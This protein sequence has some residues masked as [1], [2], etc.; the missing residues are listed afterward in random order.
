[1]RTPGRAASLLG[2]ARAASVAGP[3]A[4]A[5]K[6]ARDFLAAWHLADKD[7]PEI[8]EMRALAGSLKGE[9]RREN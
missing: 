2:L 3:R 4:E 1:V 9:V 8:A 6:A 7:R 5:I